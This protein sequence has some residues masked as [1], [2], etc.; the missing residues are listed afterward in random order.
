ML[1]RW[2][3]SGDVKTAKIAYECL[4]RVDRRVEALEEYF[5]E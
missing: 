2:S 5:V 4:R 3:V 1:F